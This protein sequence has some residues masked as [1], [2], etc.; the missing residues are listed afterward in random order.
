MYGHVATVATGAGGVLTFTGF[1]I[2]GLAILSVG[3][4]FAGVATLTTFRHRPHRP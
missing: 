2:A 3:L 1:G 4:A